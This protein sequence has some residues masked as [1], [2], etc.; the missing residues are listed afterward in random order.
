MMQ[1]E[2][3]A[4][5]SEV[6]QN[7][8]RAFPSFVAL[9]KL[10]QRTICDNLSLLSRRSETAL[11][12]NEFS[13]ISLTSP[14]WSDRRD[15]WFVWQLMKYQHTATKYR[16]A[17]LMYIKPE[18]RAMFEEVW[19]NVGLVLASIRANAERLK[20]VGLNVAPLYQKKAKLHT[21]AKEMKQ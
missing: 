8:V 21:A 19:K 1:D 11:A 5:V 6:L 2:Y 12:I 9:N 18:D 16:Q 7:A 10:A 3:D 14:G 4:R 20:R 13:L 17:F 15:V